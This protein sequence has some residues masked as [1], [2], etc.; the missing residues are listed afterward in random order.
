MIIWYIMNLAAINLFCR[1]FLADY[2][3]FI[4][5]EINME[6]VTKLNEAISYIEENIKGKIDYAT[7]AR[8][9]CCS[10][11]RFQR[12]FSLVSDTTIGDYVRYRKMALAADG[13]EKFQHKSNRSLH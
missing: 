8:I 9:A 2:D 4:S 6:W 11:T 5:E 10:F 1:V 3:T 12:T 7:A 13:I